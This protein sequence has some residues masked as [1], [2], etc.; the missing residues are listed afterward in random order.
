MPSRNSNRIVR[1]SVAFFI[2]L[3]LAL[4]PYHSHTVSSED[5][6]ISV[7]TGAVHS[8]AVVDGHGEPEA[9]GLH[10][11]CVG[12]VL[13]KHVQIPTREV[14]FVRPPL[15]SGSSIMPP[16]D[17]DLWPRVPIHGVFRPPIA[18]LV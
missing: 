4:A 7:S 13:M 1:L 17:A 2:M 18:L 9:N 15:D 16:R 11:N 8:E 14:A 12:C 10:A 6:T 3:A 5:I